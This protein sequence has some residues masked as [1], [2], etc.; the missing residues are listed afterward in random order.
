M[1]RERDRQAGRQTRDRDRQ[2]D[3]DTDRERMN[4]S[5]VFYKGRGV[6]PGCFYINQPSLKRDD[7]LIILH[8]ERERE[9]KHGDNFERL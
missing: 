1:E 8:R 2:T 5:T 9:G 7:I 3:T 6:Y 4:E